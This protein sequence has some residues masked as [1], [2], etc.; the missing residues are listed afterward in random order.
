MIYKHM[1]PFAL[2][3][4]AASCATIPTAV[5]A[6]PID[7]AIFL[8]MAGGFPASAECNAAK[9]EVIRRITPFP[10]EPPL[11]LWRCPMG[12]SAP[13][14]KYSIPKP[15]LAV[16]KAPMFNSAAELPKSVRLWLAQEVQGFSAFTTEI[17][18]IYG[19]REGAGAESLPHSTLK[20][21]DA[22]SEN[23]TISAERIPTNERGNLVFNLPPYRHEASSYN[24]TVDVERVYQRG[25]T[26]VYA[27]Y[28]GDLTVMPWIF[29]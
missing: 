27:D 7:C 5:A 6:Y 2:A 13:A 18:V 9:A 28:Q 16:A 29:Y 1:K 24:T 20:I 22:N 11:Q 4:V 3:A 21:C 14:N 19:Y 10:I 17:R 8:C 15:Q 25:I 26:I 23:C 12:A